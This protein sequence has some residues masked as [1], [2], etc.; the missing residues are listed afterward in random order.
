MALQPP[1]ILG[2]TL[3]VVHWEDGEISVIDEKDLPLELPSLEK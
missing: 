1:E 2:R 3:P